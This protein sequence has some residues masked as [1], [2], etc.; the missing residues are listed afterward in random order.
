M[1]RD[2]WVR[3]APSHPASSV[4][5]WV[6]SARPAYR[7][8]GSEARRSVATGDSASTALGQLAT[9]PPADSPAASSRSTHSLSATSAAPVRQLGGRPRIS[10]ARTS[11]KSIGRSTKVLRYMADKYGDTDD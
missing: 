9:R 2:R 4:A 11:S 6:S 8:S 5:S 1:L 3:P 7:N 10:D